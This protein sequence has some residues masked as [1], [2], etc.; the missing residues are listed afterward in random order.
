M[1]SRFFLIFLSPI[2]LLSASI[3]V[4][5]T[6]EDSLAFAT[7]E[8]LQQLLEDE[9]ISPEDQEKVYFELFDRFRN[10]KRIDE[11]ADLAARY[12]HHPITRQGINEEKLDVLQEVLPF[13]SEIKD[14]KI[15]GNLHLKTGGAWFNL[16][17]F[18]SAIVAYS[19]AISS[20]GSNDSILIAD[21]YFFRGQAEDYRGSMLRAMENY[22]QARDIY[23]AL[24]DSEYVNYVN[25]GIAILYSKFGIY[26]ESQKIR[27]QLIEDAKEKGLVTDHR[28]QLYNMAETYRKQGL[29]AAQLQA[30]KNA[31]SLLEKEPQDPYL[32]TMLYLSLSKYYGDA[33]EP[34]LQN[35]YFELAEEKR[36]TDP[37]ISD[38]N[39]A[40]L[41]AK[42]QLLLDQGQFREARDIATQLMEIAKVKEN[43][44]HLLNAYRLIVQSSENL[45]DYSRAFD[46]SENLMQYKD[47]IFTVNQAQ[48]FAFYQT[49]YETEKKERE[50]LRKS[51]ELEETKTAS[52][53][54]T[55][56]MLGVIS[57]LIILAVMLFLTT[58]LRHLRKQK[59]LEQEYAQ[60][61][62]KIQEEERKRISKDL[63][64]GLG[65]SLLLIKNKVALNQSQNA[66]E[67][68]DTA[69]SELRAIARSLHPMQLEKLGLAKALEQMLDQIDRETD[70]FVSSEIEDISNALSKE[71]EL[72][73]YRIAQ[74]SINNILKHAQAD[75]IRMI[76]RKEG[77]RIFMSIE[78]NGIGFDFSEKYQDF[79]SLGLKTLKERTAAIQGTMKVSSEKGSGAKLSFIVNV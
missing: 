12:F 37:R 30:L 54:R 1:S 27:M 59:L 62:L 46:A 15:R 50:I 55:Q 31:E 13:E 3:G 2:L 61:L 42:S 11:W 60:Q 52:R 34:E 48:S 9:Q 79:Q 32:E 44:D 21:S 75:A 7:E 56:I 71:K 57:F 40:Y 35:T 47:S 39:G 41:I 10:E 58:R 26:E 63:H 17:Q 28:I 65:Q 45:G 69:I 14:S 36:K 38:E 6:A 64:D 4:V 67:M 43:M 72:Q 20:F 73:L 5:Q 33:D 66:G 18:D 23:E 76:L 25:G 51:V 8:E 78:D 19:D 29:K 22:Q 24:G 16:Q 68:L 53:Q 49:R 70:L 77:N 74:E